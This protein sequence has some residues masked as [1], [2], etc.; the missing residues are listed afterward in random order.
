[1]V[2]VVVGVGLE[3]ENAVRIL[4]GVLN[5]KDILKADMY[6]V[7]IEVVVVREKMGVK[8]VI[9]CMYLCSDESPP[10][11]LESG[12][13]PQHRDEYKQSSWVSGS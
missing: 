5:R 1:M 7:I 10:A 13:I 6:D 9:V 2:V 12:Y 4:F 11:K 8:G 3:V